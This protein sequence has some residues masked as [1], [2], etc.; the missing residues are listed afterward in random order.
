MVINA[1]NSGST[2]FMADFE[3]EWLG[4]SSTSAK[5]PG[6]GNSEVAGWLWNGGMQWFH[7]QSTFKKAPLDALAAEKAHPLLLLQMHSMAAK[8]WCKQPLPACTAPCCSL[9]WQQPA[10][11]R[12]NKMLG[13]QIRADCFEQGSKCAPN[14]RL[15]DEAVR[16]QACNNTLST[17]STLSSCALSTATRAATLHL[18]APVKH[19]H[20]S[21]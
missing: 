11:D 2:Q 9:Q 5:R 16:C 8:H 4:S 13:M 7:A 12:Y 20:S 14:D 18:F 15:P 19:F 21:S 3:G 10:K 6:N 1:L 17:S